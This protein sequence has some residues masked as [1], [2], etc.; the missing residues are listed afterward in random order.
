LNVESFASA[1]TKLLAIAAEQLQR[2]KDAL[3]S[4]QNRGLS[5]DLY[6]GSPCLFCLQ[7]Y[8]KIPWHKGVGESIAPARSLPVYNAVT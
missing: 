7:S 1:Y 4:W 5:P 6:T 2:R 3:A 8:G